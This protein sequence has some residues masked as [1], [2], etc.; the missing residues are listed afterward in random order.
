MLNTFFAQHKFLS[1]PVFDEA[2]LK[3][4]NSLI[5][6]EA[7]AEIL[8]NSVRYHITNDNSLEKECY[9][10]IKIYD[11]KRSED[12]LNVIYLCLPMNL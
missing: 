10:K 4:P 7:P 8:Y 12:W 1:P 3:K 5:E 11:K 6:K 2:D 9:S